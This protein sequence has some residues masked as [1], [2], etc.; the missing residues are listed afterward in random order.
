M[1]GIDRMMSHRMRAI[2]LCACA[3]AFYV[4]APKLTA[5]GQSSDPS[6]DAVVGVQ[7]AQLLSQTITD[8]WPSYNGDYTGR[9]FS[10]LAQITPQNAGRLQAQW[11]FHTKTPGVLEATPVVVN[12]IMYFTGSNDGRYSGTI[13]ERFPKVLST[14]PPVISIAVW[15]S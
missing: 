15:L 2:V 5:A 14:T 6:A 8:N 11:V 4:S 7:P 3:V 1:K 13:H 12:G 9:R 10:S